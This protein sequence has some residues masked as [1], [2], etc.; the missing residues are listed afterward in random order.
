MPSKPVRTAPLL[1]RP[2]RPALPR[3]RWPLVVLMAALLTLPALQG[4]AQTSEP[5]P[6]PSGT[7]PLPGLAN[8][9]SKNCGDVGG[10]LEIVKSAQGEFGICHFPDGSSC[11]E[12]DLLRGDCAPGGGASGEGTG[13]GSDDAVR[14]QD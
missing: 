8:P 14:Q 4:V 6:Q 12:W 7:R 5:G 10:K 11:E 9:A 13:P 2:C 1:P 3:G